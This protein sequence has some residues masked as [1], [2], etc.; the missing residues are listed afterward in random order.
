M[1]PARV[2]GVRL[3]RALAVCVIAAAASLAGGSSAATAA[4]VR[5]ATRGHVVPGVAHS[6]VLSVNSD[7]VVYRTHGASSDGLWACS[8]H[9]AHRFLLIGR[10]DSA[11]AEAEYG[12]TTTLG[13]LNIAGNWVT[14]VHETGG[15]DFAGCTKY[16]MSACTG[17]L[18]ALLVVNVARGL[19]GRLASI[20]TVR[21]AFTG[22]VVSQVGWTRTLLS[23]SGAVAWLQ[24]AEAGV[25]TPLS[26]APASLYGCSVGVAG[27]ALGCTPRLLAQGEIPSASL[28]LV[29][30]TLTWTAGGTPGSAVL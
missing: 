15:A 14:V 20:V 18:D 28:A 29:A 10:D 12:P 2:S 24:N 30:S 4:A 19:R 25:T 5:C 9:G 27:G 6:R 13:Q 8:R 1:R 17:P 7:V 3:R 11:Q 21:T 16:E 26:E 22:P 23:P